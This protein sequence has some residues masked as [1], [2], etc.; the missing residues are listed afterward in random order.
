MSDIL[1]KN[2]KMPAR[3]EL[4]PFSGISGISCEL[5]S[6]TFT[7]KHRLFNDGQYIE[8]CPLI[9]VPTP[10]G[11]LIDADALKEDCRY[12][13]QK[14]FEWEKDAENEED[15]NAAMAIRSNLLWLIHCINH[16]TTIIEAEETEDG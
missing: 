1:I 5:V 15:R 12:E 6:C 7:G 9:E 10:H 4:C 8:D 16:L 3:C 14:A 13:I 11:R 2:M